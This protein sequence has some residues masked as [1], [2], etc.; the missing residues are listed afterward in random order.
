MGCSKLQSIQ[1]RVDAPNLAV[2][3]LT[4]ENTIWK[5]GTYSTTIDMAA[6]LPTERESGR[7]GGFVYRRLATY[8]VLD[9][10]GFTTGKFVRSAVRHRSNIYGI[11]RCISNTFSYPT[12]LQLWQTHWNVAYNF[13]LVWEIETA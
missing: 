10:V 8:Y 4:L 5:V 7:K 9:D 1:L 12:V 3:R 6:M 11:D 13:F 2:V